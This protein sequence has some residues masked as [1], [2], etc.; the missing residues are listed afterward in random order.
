MGVI[1]DS[2]IAAA[3]LNTFK[4]NWDVPG[5]KIKI[6]VEKG[7]VTLEGE[8]EWNY[9]RDTAKT[10]VSRL[11]SVKG[12]SNNITIKSESLD[13]LEKRDIKHAL[14]G[15]WSLNDRE[16]RVKVSGS[17]VTLSGLVDSL[18]QKDQA[19]KIAWNAPGVRSVDNELVV[20]YSDTMVE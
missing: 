13:E 15:N 19:G 7:W 8:L 14:A 3:V 18:Y 10:V 4:W 17:T 16:I 1:A 6:R 20:E 11:N 5:E 9:Q 2:E 12:V